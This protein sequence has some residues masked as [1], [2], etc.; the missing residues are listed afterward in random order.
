MNRIDK[1]VRPASVLSNDR[2]QASTQKRTTTANY[3]KAPYGIQTAQATKHHHISN[4]GK[5]IE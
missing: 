5:H 4:V 2:K 3:N 1:L